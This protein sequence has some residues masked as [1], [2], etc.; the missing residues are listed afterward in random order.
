[1][2]PRAGAL[3]GTRGGSARTHAR[4]LLPPLQRGQAVAPV[5]QAGIHGVCWRPQWNRGAA[6]G[7]GGGGGASSRAGG[8]VELSAGALAGSLVA[9][10]LGGG[11]AA[12]LAAALAQR[13]GCR[14]PVGGSRASPGEVPLLPAVQRKQPRP[15]ASADTDY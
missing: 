1:M 7:G 6:G 14:F 4:S 9:A 5:A 12:L 2:R 3:A 8:Q 13:S 11:V 15:A 10:A